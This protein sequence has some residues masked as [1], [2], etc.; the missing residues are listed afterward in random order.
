MK[1]N[2]LRQLFSP[3][4]VYWLG[5]EAPD[6][7]AFELVAGLLCVNVKGHLDNA[8]DHDELCESAG[9]IA[10]RIR[11]ESAETPVG[12]APPA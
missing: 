5:D 6:G 11:E 7:T 10:Q 2:W 8:T 12:Q 3:K 4:F 1:Q 9:V